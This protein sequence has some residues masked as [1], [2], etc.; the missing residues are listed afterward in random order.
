MLH[1]ILR[2]LFPSVCAGCGLLGEPL[3]DECFEQLEFAP[4]VRDV[5]GMKVCCSMYYSHDSELLARLVH[6]FKYKHQAE[7]FRVFVPHMVAALR[8][9][10]E[11]VGLVFVPVPLHKK[12]ELERGYNQANLLARRVARHLGCELWRGLRRVKNTGSQA[13]IT[14]SGERREN[15]RG[16][17]EVSEKTP[18]GMHLV[19]VDDIVTTGSTLLACREALLAAGA[20]KVSALTLAEREET[21]QNPWN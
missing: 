7:I 11:P 1:E 8:L 10:E 16:A 14:D 18:E 13:Q 9:L 4:H 5:F 17:F 15:I 2:F 19:L 20:E 21:P 3:C 6:P 12:R